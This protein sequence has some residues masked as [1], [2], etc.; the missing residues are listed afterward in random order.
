MRNTRF[1]GVLILFLSVAGLRAGATWAQ[2][3]ASAHRKGGAMAFALHGPFES[4]MEI[5][6]QFTCSGEDVSPALS[7]QE[8]PQ[9]TKSFVLIVHDPDAPSGDFTHWV[10]YNLP[11]TAK[12]L[13]QNIAKSGSLPDG[14]KQGRNGFGRVGYGGPCPPPGKPHRYFFKLSALDST[15]DMDAGASRSQVEEAM[16]GHVL[17]EAELMGTYRR[18]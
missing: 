11:G 10:I 9:N 14:A 16:K 3:S 7:W 6:V 13:P 5:P 15:V 18:R 4:G 2:A 8:T 1:I 12:A 17:A